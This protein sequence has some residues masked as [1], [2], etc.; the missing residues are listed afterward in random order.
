MPREEERKEVRA[1]GKRSRIKERKKR[2]SLEL[3][4]LYARGA[5]QG[6]A[7]RGWRGTTGSP[8]G[9]NYIL[10]VSAP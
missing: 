7:T 6:V 8:R 9:N 2:E 1:E 3:W 4:F 5:S 10:R